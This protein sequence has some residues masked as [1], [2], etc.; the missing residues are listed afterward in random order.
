MRNK[1]DKW[2]GIIPFVVLAIIVVWIFN[3]GILFELKMSYLYNVMI[4]LAFL[5]FFNEWKQVTS[6]KFITIYGTLSKFVTNSK[7][8]TKFWL[9]GT[10]GGI[11]VG[12]LIYALKY[13]Y[14]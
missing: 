8:D 11:F 3:A 1:Y 14:F 12:F 4:T 13:N 2:H 9:L 7:R 5:H 10:F 6:F